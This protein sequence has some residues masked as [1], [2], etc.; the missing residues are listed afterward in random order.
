MRLLPMKNSLGRLGYF[1][2]FIFLAQMIY[3]GYINIYLGPALATDP[4]NGRL[5]AAEAGILRGTI[6]DRKGLV[7]A[8]DVEENGVKKRVYPLKEVTSHLTGFVSPRYGR[9]GMESLYDSYLLAM[10]EGGRLDKIVKHMLN[11]PAYGY[12]VYTTLDAGL[13][14]KAVNL[15]GGRRGAVVALEPA[16]GAVLVMASMPGYDPNKID[17]VVGKKAEKYYA[18]GKQMEKQVDITYFDRISGDTEN[19]P[20]LD[21]AAF[22]AYPPGSTFKLVTAAGILGRDA[23]AAG[24]IYN[25]TGSIT[26]DGFVLKDNKVHGGVD[27]NSALAVSCN[28]AFA[29]YGLELGDEGLKLAARSFGFETGAATSFNADSEAVKYDRFSENRLKY[30]NYR[31]GMLPQEQ[32][33]ETEIASTA[34]GQGRILA[35]PMQMALVAAGIANRGAVMTPYLLAQVKT[36][37]GAVKDKNKPKLLHTAVTP[38]IAA[39][40]TGAM[41]EAVTR[42]TASAASIA[43]IAVAGKT[44]S[45]QNPR[46]ETHAWFVGFAPAKDPR[47]AVAVILENSGAGGT[48]AAP[49]ARAIMEDYLQG[50]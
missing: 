11:R 34:I 38:E 44:G 50:G 27:F 24:E 43:G 32:L 39:Q 31:P 37:Q 23:A 15:L 41:Q 14:K 21:R 26:V 36:V 17:Q 19:S 18:N 12:N 47:I 7:L 6:Y 9:A 42:G 46:G 48:E 8:G 1:F 35:S 45:A 5:A 40:I 16:T 49:V 33:I 13:Q 29:H 4:H 30:V 2:L 28:S 3:L 10:D 25:C 22:G 20:L